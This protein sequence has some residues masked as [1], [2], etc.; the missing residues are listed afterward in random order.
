MFY[1]SV[2]EHLVHVSLEFFLLCQKC[3]LPI[4]Y[5]QVVTYLK[6]VV[7]TKILITQS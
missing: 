3:K 6:F 2:I 7:A 5:S 1:V 4:L